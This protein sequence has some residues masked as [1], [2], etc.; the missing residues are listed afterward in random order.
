M[1]SPRVNA[2]DLVF[3]HRLG[4]TEIYAQIALAASS[5]MAKDWC[6]SGAIKYVGLLQ[7]DIR[8]NSSKIK[9]FSPWYG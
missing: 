2:V 3:D 9:L 5:N 7:T 4:Q 1:Y 8:M 6:Q